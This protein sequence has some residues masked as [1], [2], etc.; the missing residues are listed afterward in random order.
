M[1]TRPL[2]LIT[3]ASAGIGAEYARQMAAAGYDLALTARRRDRLDELAAELGR[4]HS[5]PNAWSFPPIWPIH[6]PR[7]PLW[8]PSSRPAG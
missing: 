5:A 7:K 3:G 6:R 2:A 4:D 1:I 8:R